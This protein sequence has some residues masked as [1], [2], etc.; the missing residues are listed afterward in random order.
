MEL[1]IFQDHFLLRLENLLFVITALVSGS[2]L[3]WPML[4]QRGIKEVDARA[5]VQLINYQDALVLDVR[6][7]SEYAAGHLPNSKHIPAEK[8]AERW[9]EIQKFKEKPIVVIYRSGIRSN[10]PSQVLKKNGFLQVINLMGGIDAWKRA[11]LPIA[12]R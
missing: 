10:N 1:S 3:L 7:D 4:T 11:G 6:D 12:K 9:T 2:L 8:I 5:V